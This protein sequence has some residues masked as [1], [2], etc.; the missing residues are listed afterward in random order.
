MAK[1]L[2]KPDASSTVSPSGSTSAAAHEANDFSR[3]KDVANAI[4]KKVGRKLV[5]TGD[6]I[7]QVYKV[8]FEEPTLDFV[9]DGGIPLGRFTEF[10][11]AEHSGKTRAALR[12]MSRFQKYCFNCNTPGVLD[13]VCGREMCVPQVWRGRRNTG[14]SV[15]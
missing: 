5:F 15:C 9:S 3:L 7:P 11:G 6:E 2:S 1:K 8:P 4:N 12:A 13:V 10:L 14:E